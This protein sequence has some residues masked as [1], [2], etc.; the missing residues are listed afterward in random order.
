MS[1]EKRTRAQRRHHNQRVIA[2][3]YKYAPGQKKSNRLSKK[4]PLD[5]GR[6]NCGV[7]HSHRKGIKLG[8]RNPRKKVDDDE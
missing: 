2:K 1:E 4:H 6:A 3:R 7:C 5:C 8:R